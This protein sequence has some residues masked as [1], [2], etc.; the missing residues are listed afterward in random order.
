M[1]DPFTERTLWLLLLS[2]TVQVSGCGIDRKPCFGLRLSEP[3]QVH[4]VSEYSAEAGYDFELNADVKHAHC[5]DVFQ[6]AAGSVLDVQLVAQEEN[7]TQ[8]CLP[9]TGNVTG[10]VDL[11]LAEPAPWL[12]FGTETTSEI[13][14]ATHALTVAGCVGRWGLSIETRTSS[15]GGDGDPFLP[16][17]TSGY[18]PIVMYVGF[19][20]DDPDA[21]ACAQLLAEEPRCID[22]YVV[23]L[24]RP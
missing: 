14:H 9:N 24:S 16:A 12:L 6:V 23:E 13:L 5:P 17:P 22:Y 15:Y 10:G 19:D 20:P 11:P 2:L 18:P 8:S 7:P 4:V 21:A 1:A 3:L